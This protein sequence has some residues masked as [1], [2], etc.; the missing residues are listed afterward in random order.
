M[1]VRPDHVCTSAAVAGPNAAR[2]RSTSASGAAPSAIGA[3]S[4]VSASVKSA[5]DRNAHRSLVGTMTRGSWVR[6]A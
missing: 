2:Y 6:T 1:P 5:T 3:S 4:Q